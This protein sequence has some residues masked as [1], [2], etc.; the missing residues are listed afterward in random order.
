M[1]VR[2]AATPDEIRSHV[3]EIARHAIAESKFAQD[4]TGTVYSI[5]D[6]AIQL[7]LAARRAVCDAPA[8]DRVNDLADQGCKLYDDV[9]A[10]SSAVDEM[11]DEA[12]SIRGC[13]RAAPVGALIA[14]SHK[15]ADRATAVSDDSKHLVERVVEF[16][17]QVHNIA[18]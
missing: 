13:A 17:A 14:R 18:P 2:D 9:A 11:L 5:L 3:A 1:P 8:R 12:A 4:L 10:L 7:L 6:I 16:S 15:L